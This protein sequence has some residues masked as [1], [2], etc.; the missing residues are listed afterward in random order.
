IFDFTR[1]LAQRQAATALSLLRRLF[2]QG[3]HPLRLLALIHRELR[4][5]LL[6]RDCLTDTLAG[7]WTPRIQFNALR[8]QLLPLLS[9]EQREAFGGLHPFALY[10]C[11]QN[12]S[13]TQ[14]GTLQRSVL[15]LH[16]LD[17]KLKSSAN[18]PRILLES[19]VLELCRAA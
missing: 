17:I 9:D 13:R 10:Q 6:A 5:L 1:A 18:D 16:Q 15:R 8:G 14:T 7:K 4:L 3:D 19:F 11:L 2:E 12:A